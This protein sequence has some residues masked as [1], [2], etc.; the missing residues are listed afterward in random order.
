MIHNETHEEPA[1]LQALA[2]RKHGTVHMLSKSKGPKVAIRRGVAT[3][4]L[5]TQPYD[6]SKASEKHA[7]SV[8]AQSRSAQR[9][10]PHEELAAQHK[11]HIERTL[12]T[13][14]Q[15]TDATRP[16]SGR[17]AQNLSKSR[18]AEVCLVVG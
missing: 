9:V 14:E 1:D 16:L 10:T 15:K 12:T 13:T 3:S 2:H 8:K 6:H 4:S 18:P 17:A 5:C 7:K 11:E